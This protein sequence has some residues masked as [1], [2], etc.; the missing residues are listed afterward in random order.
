MIKSHIRKLLVLKK[1]MKNWTHNDGSK[2]PLDSTQ[3][4]M[5]EADLH[6][7]NEL[8]DEGRKSKRSVQLTK[9]E[10]LNMNILFITYGGKRND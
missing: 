2:L 5:Y 7:V 6:K 1:A 8:I 4:R 3:G 10:M 9:E